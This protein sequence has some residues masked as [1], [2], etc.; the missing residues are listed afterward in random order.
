VKKKKQYNY[1]DFDIVPA[2]P[3][4]PMTE[5]AVILVTAGVQG[6]EEYV[7]WGITLGSIDMLKDRQYDEVIAEQL[8]RLFERMFQD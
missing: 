8:V 7:K 1:F 4:A 3:M 5:G 2:W 6:E